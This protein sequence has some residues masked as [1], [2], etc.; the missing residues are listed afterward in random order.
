M[1]S[2]DKVPVNYVVHFPGKWPYNTHLTLVCAVVAR[3]H[4]NIRPR[5][6]NAFTCLFN[7][8]FKRLLNKP[9]RFIIFIS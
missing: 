9:K 4:F 1:C 2:R 7:T 6:P 8:T 3:E 5:T